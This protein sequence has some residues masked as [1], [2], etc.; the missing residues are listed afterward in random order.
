M[1]EE[2]DLQRA[3]SE[4]NLRS[5]RQEGEFMAR[6]LARRNSAET[7]AYVTSGVAEVL[8][9]AQ[10]AQQLPTRHLSESPPRLPRTK[11][12]KEFMEKIHQTRLREENKKALRLLPRNEEV[13]RKEVLAA[14]TKEHNELLRMMFFSAERIARKTIEKHEREI[15]SSDFVEDALNNLEKHAD[16]IRSELF[17]LLAEISPENYQESLTRFGALIGET[18]SLPE[19]WRNFIL[20]G[21]DSSSGL[22]LRDVISRLC[23]EKFNHPKVKPLLPT[24]FLE[25]T[26][27]IE[28]RLLELRAV[29]RIQMQTTVSWTCTAVS[30]VVEYGSLDDV[31]RMLWDLEALP[32]EARRV[33]LNGQDMIADVTSATD[34]RTSAKLPVDN[35]NFFLGDTLYRIDPVSMVLLVLLQSGAGSIVRI[36]KDIETNPNGSKTIHM[37]NS[38][39]TLE[40]EIRHAGIDG[41]GN[42]ALDVLYYVTKK[43]LEAGATFTEV[44]QERIVSISERITACGGVVSDLFADFDVS[45]GV[46]ALSSSNSLY[47]PSELAASSID[48]R[49]SAGGCTDSD[50]YNNSGASPL[51]LASPPSI[52][53]RRSFSERLDAQR[54]ADGTKLLGS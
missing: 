13:A 16:K 30:G 3:R 32:E 46:P 31:E 37:A 8:H 21:S 9:R 29:Q 39:M 14:Y 38:D 10:S 4:A 42:T 35:Y 22:T 53:G 11:S 43:K 15:F 23:K 33:L 7:N 26:R 41:S 17:C 34:N 36:N 6:L 24:E 18:E 48:R 2:H 51:S 12:Q 25:A 49:S 20:S 50:V 40:A 52:T 44:E 19:G 5:K 1:K 54:R 45:A 28:L 47:L 27:E